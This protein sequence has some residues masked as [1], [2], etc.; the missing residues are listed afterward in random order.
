MIRRPPIS[1][2]FPYTT[3]FRSV[4]ARSIAGKS[5]AENPKNKEGGISKR[6]G[7]KG[8]GFIKAVQE[9]T[10]EQIKTILKEGY[11]KDI[12]LS[13]NKLKSIN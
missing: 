12:L 7:Y 10:K 1:T 8:S 2:L 13:L 11:R 5:N 9:Q 6:F 4:L 3:L